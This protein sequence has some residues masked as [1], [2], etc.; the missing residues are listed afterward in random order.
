MLDSNAA[1]NDRSDDE[2]LVFLL[3]RSLSLLW[4]FELSVS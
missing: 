1:M 2:E 4:T 3:S